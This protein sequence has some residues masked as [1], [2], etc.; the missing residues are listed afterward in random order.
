MRD[1][2]DTLEVGAR[3]PEFTLA[4]ANREETFSLAGL[5]KGGSLILEFLRGTW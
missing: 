5:L 3:A 4:A 1:H 2:T